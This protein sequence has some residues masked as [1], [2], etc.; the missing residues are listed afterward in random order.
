MLQIVTSALTAQIIHLNETIEMNFSVKWSFS[1]IRCEILRSRYIYPVRFI[2][3][4]H[5]WTFKPEFNGSELSLT[6]FYVT[7]LHLSQV[8]AGAFTDFHAIDFN[9][10]TKTNT[11]TRARNQNCKKKETGELTKASTLYDDGGPTTSLHP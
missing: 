3:S 4:G 2:H 6:E 5:E 10:D 7:F 1:V 8:K 9:S 11:G